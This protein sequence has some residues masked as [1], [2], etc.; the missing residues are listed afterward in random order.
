MTYDA[1][2][3]SVVL[4]GG[5][6]MQAAIGELN[7]TWTF[8]G[9]RWT[10]VFTAHS[11]PAR[12]AASMAYDAAT[13]T[14][15]LFGGHD[16]AGDTLGDMWSWDGTDWTQLQ[17]A[18]LPPARSYAA[19]SYDAAHQQLVLFGGASSSSATYLDDTWLYSAGDW[20]QVLLSPQP[21]GRAEAAMAYDAR[22]SVTV[23]FGGAGEQGSLNDT[24]TWDG[25]M[26]TMQV[27]TGTLPAAR[28]GHAMAY[29]AALG[30]V[31][32]TG[33][34]VAPD[35]WTWDLTSGW[36]QFSGATQPDALYLGLAFDASNQTLYE[37]SGTSNAHGHPDF[38][39]Y[40]LTSAGWSL[41]DVGALE[42]RYEP[43][44][45]YD[46]TIGKFVL[47]GGYSVIDGSLDDTWT[48]DG[49]TWTQLHPAHS[50][51][52][53]YQAQFAYEGTSGDLVLFGGCCASR[54][55]ETWLFDGTDWSQANPVS[56]PPGRGDGAFVWDPATQSDVLFGGVGSDITNDTWT[57]AHGTWTQQ[58]PVDS[59]SAR[60]RMGAAYDPTSGQVVV[61]S[62]FG[63][64]RCVAD[65]NGNDYCTAHAPDTWTWNGNDWTQAAT[66]VLPPGREQGAM[67]YD[68]T[69]GG[70]VLYGGFSEG[71]LALDDSWLFRG[72]TWQP[73]SPLASPDPG[74][75]GRLASAPGG[76]TVY[77][78]GL[79]DNQTWTITPENPVAVAEAPSVASLAGLGVMAA[80]AVAL[81]RRRR[82]GRRQAR[83][84]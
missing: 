44:F 82:R 45:T 11:P 84:H 37:F 75:G 48:F 19:M 49:S 52:A 79:Y 18:H 38:R 40:Q 41:V 76:P 46:P 55:D 77:I 78:G 73:L 43:A 34:S 2:T 67:A 69:L 64:F 21:T 27:Y 6:P 17:P 28:S 31:V 66:G 54:T 50:P 26:W 14:V 59:P 35:T 1:A 3:A 9:S 16:A 42:P 39:L 15:L 13:Q 24:W 25:S 4:F 61:F 33:G 74:Y 81:R 70:V 7:D 47:F 51:P 36:T 22:D 80:A 30:K 23:L 5:N 53:V 8:D 56:S 71:G 65:Q 57:W 32:M 68:P 72:G 60:D 29:D 63:G 10:R 12:R 62:G 58:Q 20:T 83:Q